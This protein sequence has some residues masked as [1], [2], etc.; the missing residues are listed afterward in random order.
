MH[1]QSEKHLLEPS[2]NFATS[3][4][5]EWRKVPKIPET[6][7]TQ[8]T[9]EK[10]HH[11]PAQERS[12]RYKMVKIT[13]KLEYEDC[14]D[15]S[16]IERRPSSSPNSCTPEQLS[17]KTHYCL[18]QRKENGHEFENIQL[19][20][21]KTLTE[22]KN[23]R[24][25]LIP[26]VKKVKFIPNKKAENHKSK[27]QNII[28]C[29]SKRKTSFEC[30]DLGDRKSVKQILISEKC[31]DQELLFS[32][33]SK[34]ASTSSQSLKEIPLKKLKSDDSLILDQDDSKFDLDIPDNLMMRKSKSLFPPVF[35]FCPPAPHNTTKFYCQLRKLP[36]LP[37]FE[38]IDETSDEETFSFSGNMQEP[39]ESMCGLVTGEMFS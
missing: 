17:G 37:N 8:E 21:K 36:S 31:L 2:T 30:T 3:G 13:E 19:N 35:S 22:E 15:S 33:G 24:K 14:E 5:I 6:Q 7:P 27:R 39:C 26:K 23:D 18:P 32:T 38:K 9:D 29:G 4:S 10:I 25:I 20:L 12:H 28:Y 34:S 16:E 11:Q 1:T